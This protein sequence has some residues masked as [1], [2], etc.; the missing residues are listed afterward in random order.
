MGHVAHCSLLYPADRRGSDPRGAGPTP[1]SSSKRAT[2]KL[3]KVKVN[4]SI[5]V[6][7][8]GEK[9]RAEY[10][11]IGRGQVLHDGTSKSDWPR[12]RSSSR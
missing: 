6:A 12:S 5:T 7:L 10:V 2:N 4:T 11:K 1:H 8:R 9:T 3:L